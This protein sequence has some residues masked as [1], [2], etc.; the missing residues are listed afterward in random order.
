MKT[1]SA[2]AALLMLWFSVACAQGPRA[3][4]SPAQLKDFP[5]SELSIERRGGRDSFRIWIADTPARQAQGLMWLRELPADHGML[6][7]L[8]APRP[9]N[10]WMKNTYVP[11]DMVFFD[12]EGRILAIA[13]DTK[14]LSTDIISS[15]F[16]VAGV[17]ELRAG[18]ARRRGIATGDRLRH[19][20]IGK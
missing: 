14:P 2:G 11:L 3:E 4:F 8:D 9:M 18:E 1:F 7:V 13:A 6:F 17:L 15:G 20:M 10:M 19:A 16:E 12:N 5:R